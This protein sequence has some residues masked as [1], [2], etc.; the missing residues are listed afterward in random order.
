MHAF[1]QLSLDCIERRSHTLG[2]AESSDHKPSMNS[3]LGAHVREAE[4][5]KRLGAPVSSSLSLLVRKAAELDQTSFLFVQ[6]QA[7]HALPN[8]A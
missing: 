3:R 4:K 2:N 8:S 5:V 1:V 6:L 7:E